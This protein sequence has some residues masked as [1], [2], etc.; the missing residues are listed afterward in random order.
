MTEILQQYPTQIIHAIP[1]RIRLRLY[2]LMESKK[3]HK[4]LQE[5]LSQ[6][7]HVTRIRIN[8][9][10]GSVVIYYQN[11]GVSNDR[12]ICD[13]IYLSNTADRQEIKRE[14]SPTS[15]EG[16]SQGAWQKLSI[17]IL[18]TG[19]ALL[20]NY[21]SIP[22]PRIMPIATLGAA[23]L[24]IV[25]KAF[26]SL[27]LDRR[28][29][30][31]CLD[32]IALSLSLI[33]G[34]IITPA[35]VITLHE[36]GDIIREQTA[37]STEIQTADLLDTI[38]RFAWVKRDG[39]IV[40]IASDRVEKGETVIVYPGEQIP[41]DGTVL[42]GKAT[43]DRS[44]L[45][46][47]SLP[48]IAEVGTMVYASELLRSG[49]LHIEAQR[50]GSKT[51]AAASLELLQNAPVYDT[52][53]ENYAAKI[54]DK[55]IVP[56]LVLAGV[57]LA[58]TGDPARAASILT[59][60]FVTGIRVSIPTAFLGALNHTTRHGVLVRSGRTIELL[61]EID[62]IVFDKTGTLTLGD[63][64]II[65]VNT[66]NGS[67]SQKR[68]LQLAASV[69]QRLTHPVAETIVSYARE[70]NIEILPR[71][72]WEYKVGLGVNAEIDGEMVLVGSAR[73]LQQ[74]G[75][76][77]NGF[78]DRDRGSLIY[79][80][81]NGEFQ[82]TIEYADPLRSQSRFVTE[83]LQNNYNIEVHLLT[84]DNQKR[85][86]EVA[87]EL[88]IPLDRVHAEAFPE[89]KAAIV[90]DLNRSGKTVAMVGDGL[91]DSV[92]LAYADVAVSFEDGSDVARETADVVLMTNDLTSFL[93]AIVI[94]KQTKRIV[95]QNTFLVVAPNL[96]ALGVASTL[97]LNPT[98]ATLVH[99][100][101]AIAAGINSLYPLVAHQ[102]EEDEFRR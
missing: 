66:V 51:R 92:A 101:S 27:W 17:S 47:E 91:N 58:A 4:K 69:E 55:L 77:L 68:L 88:N 78:C 22:I 63:L 79:L 96:V 1:G 39:E 50:I 31:D 62:T 87:K 93:E 26:K 23:A 12:I 102:L 59:L 99:N 98:I 19:L 71:Q 20:R 95:E 86:I 11:K 90:R 54:A 73:F 74:E 76:D 44:S 5:R 29:N 80:A 72:D 81:C 52:R 75:I 43:V 82:G 84:G 65:R 9:V 38:G 10:A 36:L 25:Q 53:M 6:N 57:V 24:P 2:R 83:T 97:G 32:F 40:K 67:I 42:K 41:V 46:G 16:S 48:V 56:S 21:T 34:K 64:T 7:S 61:A 30:I 49:Q 45:T 18:A 33:Q 60:D 28:L 3:Y 8:R 89:T 37:R 100:G 35:L 94:T 70:Q 14:E 85:A 15:I 13:L